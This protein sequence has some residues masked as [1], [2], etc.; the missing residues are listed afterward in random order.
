M[1]T[2]TLSEQCLVLRKSSI[3][4]NFSDSETT[5]NH[6]EEDSAIDSDYEDISDGESTLPNQH[7]SGHQQSNG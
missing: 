4:V 2:K 6:Q 1:K 3:N 7:E 5:P